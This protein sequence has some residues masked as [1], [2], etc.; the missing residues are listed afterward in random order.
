MSGYSQ[1]KSFAVVAETRRKFTAAEKEAIVG[2][3]AGAPVS[4]VARRHGL[5]SSLVFRWRRELRASGKTAKREGKT[6]FIPVSLPMPANGAAP[7]RQP[8]DDR[9]AGMIEIELAGGR[10][11]RVTGQVETEALRRVIAALEGR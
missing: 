5:A 10:R 2:E 9:H 4:S 3:T 6:A 7:A 1:E 11:V 8:A